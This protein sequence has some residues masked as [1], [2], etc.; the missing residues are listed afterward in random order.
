MYV[1]LTWAKVKSEDNMP[2]VYSYGKVITPSSWYALKTYWGVPM[3]KI[4][5]PKP[6]IINYCKTKTNGILDIPDI[7]WYSLPFEK[8]VNIDWNKQERFITKN[9][10]PHISNHLCFSKQLKCFIIY[11][12]A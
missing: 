10:H 4:I 8:Y 2:L 1:L 7:R 6:L 11:V 3:Y 5:L 9:K 12:L